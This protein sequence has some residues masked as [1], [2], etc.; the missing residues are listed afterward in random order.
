[1]KKYSHCCWAENR[2]ANLDGP[3]WETIGMCPECK[4][5]CEFIGD[6]ELADDDS[7]IKCNKCDKTSYSKEDVKNLYCGSCHEFHERGKDE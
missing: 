4:E 6:Y 5:H 1:M 3:D 2:L 7:W